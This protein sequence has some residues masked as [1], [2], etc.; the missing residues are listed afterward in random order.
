METEGKRHTIC[1]C[2]NR[3]YRRAVKWG[4]FQKVEAAL[5]PRPVFM[6]L[7]GSAEGWLHVQEK[8]KKKHNDCVVI[9][10]KTDNFARTTLSR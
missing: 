1:L 8:E 2:L 3:W 9:W 7:R 4:V 10:R 6:T 5:G